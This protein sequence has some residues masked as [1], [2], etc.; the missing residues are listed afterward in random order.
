MSKH[1]AALKV[2][3][4]NEILNK[5]PVINKRDSTCSQWEK[6]GKTG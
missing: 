5:L 2:E 4:S 6:K 1:N 3:I